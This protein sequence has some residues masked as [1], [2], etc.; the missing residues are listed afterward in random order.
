MEPTAS[1]SEV[2]RPWGGWFFGP[3]LQ[4]AGIGPT[5]FSKNPSLGLLCGRFYRTFTCRERSSKP[6]LR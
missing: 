1:P 2:N 4:R 6:P 3:H 5:N